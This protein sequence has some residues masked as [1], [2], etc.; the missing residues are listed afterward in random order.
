MDIKD[1]IRKLLALADSPNDNEAIAALSK[2]RELMARHKLT[3][4]DI[5]IKSS[6]VVTEL[7]DIYHTARSS[8]WV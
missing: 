6:E 2:A 7:L 5:D 1:K 3:E 4:R 8:I